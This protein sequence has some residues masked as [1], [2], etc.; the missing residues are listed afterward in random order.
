[1]YVQLEA[2]MAAYKHEECGITV[3]PPVMGPP[4]SD[5]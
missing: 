1:M 2:V 4:I 5:F 3:E